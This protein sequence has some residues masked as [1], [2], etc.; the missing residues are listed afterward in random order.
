MYFSSHVQKWAIGLAMFA[1]FFGSGNLIFPLSIGQAA[2]S[3]YFWAMGGFL[4]SGVLLPFAGVL[5]MVLYEGDYRRF[6]SCLGERGGF[7]FAFALLTAWI[8]LGSGPRCVVLC[9]A[10]ITPYFSHLSLGLFSLIYCAIMY[11]FSHKK[12]RLL[13]IL[14]Y[15]LTPLLLFC[16]LL[17]IFAGLSLTTAEN[18]LPHLT[19][20]LNSLQEGY[21]T[22]DLIA[23]FF[24]ASTII[25]I[26]KEVGADGKPGHPKPLTLALKSSIVGMVLLGLVYAGL[27]AVAAANSTL[28][29]GVSKDQLLATLV[30]TLMGPKMRILATAAVA[31]ACLTT[32]IA[33]TTVYADFL[34]KSFFK[35]RISYSL[36]LLL[37]TLL[38]FSLSNLGFSG[39]MTLS[40]PLMRFFYPLLI[41]LIAWH[42]VLYPLLSR[43]LR[44]SWQFDFTS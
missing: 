5:T 20:L 9:F 12:S 28:L 11:A 26:L 4:L 25:T 22:M 41:L 36:S 32:S 14:G 6:F 7:L 43:I 17:I 10:N 24:F 30:T 2:G 33:L 23:S 40:E 27:I 8:P 42:L 1:M 15:V 16:L 21:N 38:T 29:E 31:L 18:S 35:E 39:I 19:L 3:G 13:D 44:G 34:H 37:T